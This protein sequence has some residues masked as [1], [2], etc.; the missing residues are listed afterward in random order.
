M[1]LFCKRLIILSVTIFA[2]FTYHLAATEKINT[3]Q[4][5]TGTST[6]TTRRTHM[7]SSQFKILTVQEA[8]LFV[9]KIIQN[10]PQDAAVRDAYEKEQSNLIARCA[11]AL[12]ENAYSKVLETLQEIDNRLAYWQYQ[13]DHSWNY[14][15]TKNPMKWFTGP[16]Q[17]E[18]IENNLEQ[19]KNHQGELYVLLGQLS[20]RGN[21]FVQGYKDLFVSDY[22]KSY[23]WVDGLLDQLA[24]IKIDLPK[25]DASS[26]FIVR[27]RQ[28]QLKLENVSRFKYMLLSDIPETAIPGHAERHW[29]KYGGLMAGL[30]YGYMHPEAIVASRDAIAH[31]IAWAKSIIVDP[32][33]TTAKEVMH[34]GKNTKQD[35][36]VITRDDAV[37]YVHDISKKYNISKDV[38]AKTVADVE[39]GGYAGILEFL[40]FVKAEKKELPL[41]KRNLYGTIEQSLD[42][43]K[44]LAD[45]VRGNIL[46]S[47]V[48]IQDLM[49]RLSGTFKLAL[50]T[51]AALSGWLA[52]AGYQKLTARDY[53]S[54][55][56]ALVDIN[57]LFVDRNKQLSDEDYGK[58]TYLIYKLKN[59]A[60]RTL[61]QKNN[62]R[63]DFIHDLER[64]QSKEFDV[65][66][67]RAIV[68]DMFK[69][70]SFLGLIQKK[71]A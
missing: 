43:V 58:M 54:L 63:A 11:N 68:E 66:A 65:A 19:L 9:R 32:L 50:F 64:I 55:R 31:Q 71:S 48:L 14:F 16:T 41:L 10:F 44:A 67:K 70:Y 39:N 4:K 21:A 53:S 42:E 22:Q 2:C 23:E 18:E 35:I 47:H 15:I 57:S 5:A 24:R 29:L 27:A 61:S 13:K 36:S 60:E 51:P 8:L 6:P 49:K 34:A 45:Y 62:L 20:E 37:R 59:Q 7:V 56:R 46:S 33:E 52:Y 40:Q 28:L 69:K 30:W 1:K 17:G 25:D 3:D 12:Y 38:E 26:P